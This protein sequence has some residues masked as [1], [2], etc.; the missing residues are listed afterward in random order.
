MANLALAFRQI[1]FYSIQKLSFFRV[2]S[3]SQ[4]FWLTFVFLTF[5]TIEFSL[6]KFYWI[7]FNM[8]YEIT[9]IFTYLWMILTWKQPKS[10]VW[11]FFD[12]ESEFGGQYS[13]FCHHRSLNCIWEVLINSKFSYYLNSILPI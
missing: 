8:L 13:S 2:F 3:L 5:W 10:I 12:S 6:L 4:H 11:S 7:K 1:F 9:V